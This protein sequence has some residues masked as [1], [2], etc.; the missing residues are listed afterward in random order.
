MWF[1][2]DSQRNHCFSQPCQMLFWF[3][4]GRLLLG[5]V[6]ICLF[7]AHAPLARGCEACHV[8][9]SAVK[10]ILAVCHLEIHTT[11]TYEMC[12]GKKNWT[13]WNIH[14]DLS[15]Y[16][17]PHLPLWPP[18][19]FC[20]RLSPQWQHVR[21]AQAILNHSYLGMCDLVYI[22][23]HDGNAFQA[24]LS[25]RLRIALDERI[26]SQEW[27]RPLVVWLKILGKPQHSPVEKF[28]LFMRMAKQLGSKINLLKSPMFSG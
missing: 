20:F 3:M 16:L 21:S 4:W 6:R 24:T 25:I 5:S 19:V 2:V 13:T 23:I 9:K 1:F 11:A 15:G 10:N 7:F 17:R 28:I 12:D 26:R 8:S 14:S 27:Q 22:T 18:V